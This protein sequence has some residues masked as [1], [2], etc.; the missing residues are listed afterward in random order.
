MGDYFS[1]VFRSTDGGLLWV[2]T[3][4]EG[5]NSIVIDPFFPDTLYAGTIRGVYTSTTGG[6]NWQ[7][8]NTGLPDS[9]VTCIGI[10]SDEFLYAGTHGT[11]M[12]RWSLNTSVKEH[13]PHQSQSTI[14]SVYP[15]PS[16]ECALITYSVTTDVTVQLAVYDACGR[17]IQ[18]LVHTRHVPG[19]YRAEWN[20]CGK[21]NNKVSTGIYF[22]RLETPQGVSVSKLVYYSQQ[23]FH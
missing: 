14:L 21:N 10:S 18:Q 22:V 23:G 9:N 15:N 8:M 1:G 4:C 17:Q 3:G 13:N 5:V 19:V 12:Y 11:G 2:N 20:G 16:P 7:S 6:V